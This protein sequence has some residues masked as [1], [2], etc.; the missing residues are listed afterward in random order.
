MSFE[1][2]R[3]VFDLLEC[4]DA[5]LKPSERLG[6]LAPAVG[7]QTPVPAPR[8]W[9]WQAAKQVDSHVLR[10]RRETP[11][12][13]EAKYAGRSDAAFKLAQQVFDTVAA[14]AGASG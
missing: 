10:V 8:R 6:R 13:R 5:G 11:P 7:R 4:P 12:R 9:A 2:L 14:G 1:A 3:A